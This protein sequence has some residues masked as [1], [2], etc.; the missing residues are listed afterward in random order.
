MTERESAI[1]Y[2]KKFWKLS[3]EQFDVLTNREKSGRER[4]RDTFKLTPDEIK[5]L[6]GTIGSQVVLSGWTHQFEWDE[7]EWH[8]TRSLLAKGELLNISVHKQDSG[9]FLIDILYDNKGINTNVS[10]VTQWR[11]HVSHYTNVFN[12]I[13]VADSGQLQTVWQRDI[14]PDRSIPWDQGYVEDELYRQHQKGVDLYL[15]TG[16]ALLSI[17]E[18]LPKT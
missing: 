8:Y 12:K 16:K 3:D 7:D 1:S 5:N 17:A 14:E 4:I 11:E 13:Q 9:I 15:S 2:L 18:I 6:S 10:P